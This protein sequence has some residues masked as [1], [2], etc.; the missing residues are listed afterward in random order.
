MCVGVA[1]G[2]SIVSMLCYVQ[3]EVKVW[4]RERDKERR[5]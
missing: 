2:D 4:I 5:G 1:I 3:D